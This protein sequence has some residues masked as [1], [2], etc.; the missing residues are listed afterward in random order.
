MYNLLDRDT[1]WMLLTFPLLVIAHLQ[2]Y[3]E[4]LFNLNGKWTGSTKMVQKTNN[5]SSDRI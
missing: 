5:E 1:A 2:K 4:P 3:Y